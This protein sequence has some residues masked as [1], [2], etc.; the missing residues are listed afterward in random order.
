[1]HQ[2]HYSAYIVYTPLP[3]AYRPSGVYKPLPLPHKLHVIVHRHSWE[4]PCEINGV[5]NYRIIPNVGLKEDKEGFLPFTTYGKRVML[6]MY[7][8]YR[9]TSSMEAQST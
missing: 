2:K 1:M 5:H 8:Y 9:V 4:L 6:H 3:R 7:M